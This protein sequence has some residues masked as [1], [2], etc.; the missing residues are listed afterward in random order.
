MALWRGSRW[1]LAVSVTAAG[2]GLRKVGRGLVP[3]AKAR[4]GGDSPRLEN[5]GQDEWS[6]APCQA[7]GQEGAREKAAANHGEG[8]MQWGLWRNWCLIPGL[9]TSRGAVP[10]RVGWTIP[11]VSGV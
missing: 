6:G 7:R 4:T 9:P 2:E 1:F 10:G 8:M 3:R 11:L 5:R